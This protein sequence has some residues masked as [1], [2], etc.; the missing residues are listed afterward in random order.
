MTGEIPRVR[1]WRFSRER[2]TLLA[3]IS[4]GALVDFVVGK[5]VHAIRLV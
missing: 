1:R 4:L 3:I 5:P 2:L